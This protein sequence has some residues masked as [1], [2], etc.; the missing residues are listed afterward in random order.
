MAWDWW[1]LGLGWAVA[2]LGTL[3][4]LGSQPLRKQV[5]C[6]ASPAPAYSQF[7][8]QLSSLHWAVCLCSGKIPEQIVLTVAV[9]L[10]DKLGSVEAPGSCVGK[11]CPEKPFELCLG[12]LIR[13][14]QCGCCPN[15]LLPD[16]AWRPGLAE[17]RYFLLPFSCVWDASAAETRWWVQ[18]FGGEVFAARLGWALPGVVPG[19]AVTTGCVSPVA[20]SS[21]PTPQPAAPSPL[22]HP[23]FSAGNNLFLSTS[24]HVSWKPGGC[25]CR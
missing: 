19:G 4:L 11:L 3:V 25:L 20:C 24:F 9:Y 5:L 12:E 18:G 14:F 8:P 23:C 13:R 21:I 2:S 6:F 16:Q 10:R 1:E 17:I 22:P 7:L 15:K